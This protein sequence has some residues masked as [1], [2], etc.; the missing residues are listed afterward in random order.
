MPEEQPKPSL[1]AKVLAISAIGMIVGFGTC[2]L[3]LATGGRGA[4]LS[5]AGA[6]IFFL[7]LVTLVVTILG[8]IANLLTE[9]FR[10]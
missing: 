8:L 7:S 10:K 5:S 3:P 9:T 1:A 4:F 2:S 6:V